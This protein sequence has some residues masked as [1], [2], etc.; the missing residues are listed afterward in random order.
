MRQDCETCGT[1]SSFPVDF[2]WISGDSLDSLRLRLATCGSQR[3]LPSRL[4]HLSP[5][6]FPSLA[7]LSRIL[8]R[9][10]LQR[11]EPDLAAITHSDRSMFRLH[12]NQHLVTPLCSHSPAQPGSFGRLADLLG[13]TFREAMKGAGV[14][15]GSVQGSVRFLVKVSGVCRC[16]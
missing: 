11:A 12:A 1:F 16:W 10:H 8:F 13:L 5:P 7:P 4:V 9:V 2:R 3:R 15:R 6:I 14:C